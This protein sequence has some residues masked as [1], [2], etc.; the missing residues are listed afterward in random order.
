MLLL[1]QGGE[2]CAALEGALLLRQ[3]GG[4]GQGAEIIGVD[5]SWGLLLFEVAPRVHDWFPE[6]YTKRSRDSD[7]I[8]R[9]VSSFRTG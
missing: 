9:H 5:V 6:I 3:G 8:I 1:A 4:P 7:G 2:L